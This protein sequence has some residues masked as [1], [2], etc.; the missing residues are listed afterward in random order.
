MMRRQAAIKA[1]TAMRRPRAR[2]G[3]QTANRNAQ[4]QQQADAAQ[5]E[6][7]RQALQRQ[8]E[9]ASG[10]TVDGKPPARET[11]QQRGQ[12]QA[13]EAWL[14]RVPDDPGGLLRARFQLEQQRRER[15]GR[16]MSQS[17][18]ATRGPGAMS[19]APPW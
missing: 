19:V 2:R 1:G 11:A 13:V 12:R 8:Q 4:T 17:I 5:R 9:Q 7:M 16:Q 6:K 18:S 14:R 10:Q 15:E 3:R